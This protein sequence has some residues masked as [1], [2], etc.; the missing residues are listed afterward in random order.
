MHTPLRFTLAIALFAAAGAAFADDCDTRETAQ[1]V[2]AAFPAEYKILDDEWESYVDGPHA[3]Y[4]AIEAGMTK[5]QAARFKARKPSDE[6]AAT[7]EALKKR[8]AAAVVGLP[9]EVGEQYELYKQRGEILK[10]CAMAKQMVRATVIKNELVKLSV[11]EQLAAAR[12][13]FPALGRK[14]TV[15]VAAANTRS[16][17]ARAEAAADPDAVK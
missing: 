17:E 16:A 3:E 13:A 10:A 4:R 6:F 2:V 1:K 11:M 12:K 5:A 9:K 7:M 8:R 14:A 15:T